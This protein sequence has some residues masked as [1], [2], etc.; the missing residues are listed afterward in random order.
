M[1]DFQDISFHYPN[2]DF[3]MVKN[4]SFHVDKKEFVCLI[5]A[6]GCGKSTIFRLINGLEQPQSGQ[7]TMN[8]MPIQ[9]LK[10]YSAYM[11][12]K[13]LLF[14]WRTIEKNICLPMELQKVP[15]EEQKKHCEEVLKEAGLLEYSGK[16]PRNLSGG[17]K[18]RVSFA[19]TLLTGSEL[20]L[21]DE[22]FSALD[23]LTRVDMQ[24]W[25]LKQWE[26]FHKTILFIT[27]DVEEAIFLSKTIYVIQE[28][29]IS[30]MEKI[31]VP[32]D[33]PRNRAMLQK[34]EIVELKESL[35][36]KLRQE[37]TT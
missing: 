11:P 22:P 34:T 10:N 25:L 35:I 5:G 26:H 27:H 13:D 4:L 30:S 36:Q 24:E 21:L 6:S 20:L 29:P 12:Q 14:P 16:Y 19:R 18:Q 33:Y 32:L 8:G 3:F 9:K 2:E 15:K 1:L 17:M 31:T 7:I 37:V 28:R 23:F